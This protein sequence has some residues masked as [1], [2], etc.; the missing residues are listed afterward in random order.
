[1]PYKNKEDKR[2][3]DKKYRQKNKTRIKEYQKMWREKN[4]E[5]TETIRQQYREYQKKYQKKYSKKRRKTDLK[6]NLNQK[7]RLG[8]WFSLKGNKNGYH[9]ENLVGYTT[10][11]L[12][13]RLQK[14]MPKEYTWQ[15]FLDGKLH[16][17]HIIPVSV[18]NFTKPEHIDFKRCWA[19]N[20]LQLLPAK[21][22]I[23]KNA[24]LYKPFQPSLK[25]E[26]EEIC[27]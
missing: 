13:K 12:I 9:W 25:V 15:D 3:N 19:L 16:I 6:Y 5:K 14:T 18:F 27:T 26:L 10:K 24:K 11:D 21:E 22:N 4:K 7:M 20:N 17:D 1:M 23:K 8:I 2:N